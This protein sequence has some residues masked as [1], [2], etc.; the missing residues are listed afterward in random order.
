MRRKSSYTKANCTTIIKANTNPII[1]LIKILR[2]VKN[3]LF[4]TYIFIRQSNSFLIFHHKNIAWHSLPPVSSIQVLTI[5]HIWNIGRLSTF[6]C[7][8]SSRNGFCRYLHINSIRSIQGKAIYHIK[9]NLSNTIFV[10][11]RINNRFLRSSHTNLCNL[12]HASEICSTAF[13][14]IGDWGCKLISINRLTSF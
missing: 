8:F 5:L 2:G 11:W 3:Y 6:R 13:P 7:P 1:H 14:F 10:E 4:D 9:I 12:L